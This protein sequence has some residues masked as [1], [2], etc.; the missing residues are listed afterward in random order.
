MIK[1]EIYAGKLV[2][3]SCISQN[4]IIHELVEKMSFDV[5]FFSNQN[6]II[7]L[8]YKYVIVKK[9][10]TKLQTSSR[11]IENNLSW[12]STFGQLLKKDQFVSVHNK[13]LQKFATD[14]C[15][16][17]KS[18]SPPIMT[19]L[20]KPINEDPYNLRYVSQFNPLSVNTV[21]RGTERSSFLGPKIWKLLPNEIFK[22]RIK[23]WKP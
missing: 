16:A 13:N 9:T 8:S 23:N 6:L 17:S 10:I 5:R 12:H 22:I 14:I 19:E 15:K 1:F 21:Y 2:I 20:F 7:A 11:S 4:I 18:L 3:N